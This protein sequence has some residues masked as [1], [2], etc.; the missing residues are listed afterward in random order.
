MLKKCSTDQS[1]IRK[2]NT[3]YK[4][5]TLEIGHNLERFFFG[6]YLP[7]NFMTLIFG[8]KVCNLDE[9]VLIFS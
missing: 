8:I 7:L 1:F 9:D 2:R 4:I 3:T 5:G 6:K